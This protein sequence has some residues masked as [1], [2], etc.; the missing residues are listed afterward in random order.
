MG[1]LAVER[2]VVLA[3]RVEELRWTPSSLAWVLAVQPVA[4]RRARVGWTRAM[5]WGGAERS[6]TRPRSQLAAAGLAG[7]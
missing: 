4:L 3:R 5:R 6:R 2:R 1:E 7:A